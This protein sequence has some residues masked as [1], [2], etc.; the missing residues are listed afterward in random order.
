LL[1]AVDVT[2][3]RNLATPRSEKMERTPREARKASCLICARSVECLPVVCSPE[4]LISN[5]VLIP[6]QLHVPTYFARHGPK[7]FRETGTGSLGSISWM[8][9]RRSCR[10]PRSRASSRA[11]AQAHN[12]RVAST[13]MRAACRALSVRKTKKKENS[14]SAGP[15]GLHPLVFSDQPVLLDSCH[16][17][18]LRSE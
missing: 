4:S 7:C 5:G 2:L 16:L 3:I 1:R 17:R 14:G 11:Y 10:P 12:G 8:I 18:Q 6:C 9:F 15:R 13:S